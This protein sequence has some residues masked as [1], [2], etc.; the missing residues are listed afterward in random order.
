MQTKR[1]WLFG[2]WMFLLGGAL[3]NVIEI[4]WR[5]RTHWSMF[6]VGGVCFRL[7][8]TVFRVFSKRCLLTRCI[9][10][11]V[12]ITTAEFISGYILN[13]RCRLHVWDYTKQPLNIK[14]QVCALYSLLW[15]FLSIPAG[16]LHTW[17]EGR[18]FS[19]ARAN[20]R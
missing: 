3:Y 4:C 18:L 19:G 1:M 2:I 8:G 20:I 12:V 10:S 11:S 14:G 16:Y 17:C 5:R 15:A 7:I 6:L 9:V 13:V